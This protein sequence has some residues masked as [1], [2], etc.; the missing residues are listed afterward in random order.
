MPSNMSDL[1]FL[2]TDG[3][4]DWNPFMMLKRVSQ[5]TSRL[6]WHYNKVTYNEFF[7]SSVVM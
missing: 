7:E 6:L 4:C 5:G 2:T 1:V 3:K